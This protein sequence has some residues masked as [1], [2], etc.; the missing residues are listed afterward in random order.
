M[1]SIRDLSLK[2][3]INFVILIVYSDTDLV[4]SHSYTSPIHEYLQGISI[5]LFFLSIYWEFISVTQLALT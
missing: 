5:F 2:K 1:D 4:T 3:K